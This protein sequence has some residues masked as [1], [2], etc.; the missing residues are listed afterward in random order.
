MFCAVQKIFLCIEQTMNDNF[1]VIPVPFFRRW[2]KEGGHWMMKLIKQPKAISNY[3]TY[4][5]GIDKSEQ[6]IGSYDVLSKSRRWWKTLF[7]HM[8]D[9][10]VDV[11]VV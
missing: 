10:R 9:V 1:V 2:C 3:N 6:M 11:A 7:F 8:V 5:G 4:M